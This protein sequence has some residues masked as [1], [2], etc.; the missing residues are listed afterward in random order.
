MSAH[1]EKN[2]LDQSDNSEEKPYRCSGCGTPLSKY[3]EYCPNC[4]R[5]NP[6][7]IYA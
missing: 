6:H 7:S 3:D 5:K 4:E 2:Q 1:Q